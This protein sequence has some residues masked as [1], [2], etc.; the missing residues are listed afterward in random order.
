MNKF[1]LMAK[2]EELK[3][4]EHA[5]LNLK[6]ALTDMRDCPMLG[7]TKKQ[8]KHI[9]TVVENRVCDIQDELKE[10]PNE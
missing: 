10:A 1:E 4:V 8:L 7:G 9:I 3:Y 2:N 5:L 6:G